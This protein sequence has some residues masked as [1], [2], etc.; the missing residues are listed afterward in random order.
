MIK[1]FLKS[2]VPAWWFAIA[3]FAAIIGFTYAAYVCNN[4]NSLVLAVRQSEGGNLVSPVQSLLASDIICER[5][6]INRVRSWYHGMSVCGP[7]REM[8]EWMG[9]LPASQ[10][11]P[12]S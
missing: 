6:W 2:T 10:Y 12:R 7:N 5:D 11:R 8:Y 1:N 3:M 9:D 4:L